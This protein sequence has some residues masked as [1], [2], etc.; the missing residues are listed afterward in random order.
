MSRAL[1]LSLRSTPTRLFLLMNLAAAKGLTTAPYGPTVSPSPPLFDVLMVA[2]EPRK[3]PPGYEQT[4]RGHED[5]IGRVPVGD[6]YSPLRFGKPENDQLGVDDVDP[7]PAVLGGLNRRSPDLQRRPA[8]NGDAR[9]W[10]RPDLPD[11]EG[12]GAPGLSGPAPGPGASAWQSG[13]LLWGEVPDVQAR[14]S[15][16]QALFT[17]RRALP[18]GEP[19]RLCFDGPTVALNPA[20]V[21]VDVATLERRVAEG[22]PEALAHAAELYRGDL[23]LGFSV[24]EPLFEDWLVAERERLRELII[25]A[26][27][28][29]LRHQQDAGALEVAVPIAL[30]LLALDQLQEP[31]HRVLMRLYDRLGRRE[32]ALRQYAH[33]VAAL[34][35]ELGLAPEAETEA[36]RREI[37]HRRPGP[38]PQGVAEAAS[39]PPPTTIGDT[40]LVGRQLERARLDEALSAASQGSGRVVLIRGE[41]GIGKTRL[42]AMLYGRAREKGGG[43]LLGHAYETE[44]TLP[45]GPWLDALRAAGVARDEAL[46]ETV[47]PVWRAELARLLPEVGAPPPP[48]AIGADTLRLFEGVARL[49]AAQAVRR[50]L[51]L[52]LED[53]HWADDTSLQLLA[54]VARRVAAWPVLL[55]VTAREEEPDAGSRGDAARARARR[56]P[57][58][59][60]ARSALAQ[61]HA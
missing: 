59:A 36:L 28:R 56:H 45:F 10:A 46:L 60:P 37:L 61:G 13:A 49:I 2:R 42:V 5:A 50:P 57:D 20:G 32:A 29:L 44:Q 1:A 39:A 38:A 52:V 23:L 4:S 53:L 21:E 26:L 48:A 33:C 47:G 24:T 22:T 40:P 19:S 43:V 9:P 12:R 30:Q 25:E 11:P 3:D 15:L 16:R 14:A 58:P 34:Q 7:A 54:F 31:V 6:E 18:G 8:L 17:L 51:L 41:A 35:G 27:A 55:V